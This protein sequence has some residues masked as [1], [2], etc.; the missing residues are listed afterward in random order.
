MNYVYDEWQHLLT[1][2]LFFNCNKN[3]HKINHDGGGM[4]L[5]YLDA[6]VKDQWSWMCALLYSFCKNILQDLESVFELFFGFST[7]N[8]EH[9]PTSPSQISR[10]QPT[11]WHSK[12]HKSRIPSFLGTTWYPRTFPISHTNSCIKARKCP[13][14]CINLYWWQAEKSHVS[15]QCASH[16]TVTMCYFKSLTRSFHVICY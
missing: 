2:K 6:A 7:W 3:I 13:F 11:S 10:A 15:S 4:I 14:I 1:Q 12:D 5:F 16:R 8:I 9:L